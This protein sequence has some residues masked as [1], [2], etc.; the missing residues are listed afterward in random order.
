[1][2]FLVFK[3]VLT[4]VIVV[5]VSE[6][7][8]RWDGLG[9]LIAAMPLTTV[10]VLIWLKV[11]GVEAEKLSNHAVYTLIYVVPTLPMFAVFPVLLARLGFWPALGV[12][13][14]VTAVC[15]VATHLAVQRWGFRLL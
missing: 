1:M 5:I 10:L 3:T 7:A 2:A 15:V 11:E 6:V 12:S 14:L 8:K 13:L 9:G 4:A